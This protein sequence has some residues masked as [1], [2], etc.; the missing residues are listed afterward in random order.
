[1]SLRRRW[2]LSEVG[3]ACPDWAYAGDLRPLCSPTHT[4]AGQ[5]GNVLNMKITGR[6]ALDPLD[7]RS[8]VVG[9]DL[10]LSEDGHQ[11][12]VLHTVDSSRTQLLGSF[13][14][15]VEAWRAVDQLDC[16]DELDIAA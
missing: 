4:F 9:P 16:A 5:R 6:P 2:K 1:M 12:V 10:V 7:L 15:V 11:R 8:A 13:D 14:D 3:D